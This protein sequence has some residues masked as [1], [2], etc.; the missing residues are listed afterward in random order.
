MFRYRGGRGGYCSYLRGKVVGREGNWSGGFFSKVDKLDF[1]FYI[2]II[3]KG[4]FC[5]KGIMKFILLF[6]K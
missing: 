6:I 2:L 5:C 4:K 1:I 3:V